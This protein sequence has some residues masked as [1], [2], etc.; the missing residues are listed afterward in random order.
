MAIKRMN[1]YK[2]EFLHAEDFQCEQIF[3]SSLRKIHNLSLHTLGI[4]YGL[5]VT[6]GAGKVTVKQGMAIDSQGREL[7]LDADRDVAVNSPTNITIAYWE[8]DDAPITEAGFT[9]VKQSTVTC[10][11][12]AGT[13]PDGIVL[14]TVTNAA[15]NPVTLNTAYKR[16]YASPVANGDVTIGGNL[17]VK[18]KLTV[19]G[20]TRMVNTDRLEGNVILGDADTDTVTVEGSLLTG[21]TSG[22][23]KIGSPVDITGALSVTESISLPSSKEI[24]FADNGQIRCFDNN[25]RILFRRTE[26][27]LELREYGD[28]V[29][30][31]GATA[32]VETAKVVMQ[33]NGNVGI[34]TTNPSAHLEI[35][36]GWGDWF[37]LKQQRTVEG[38]GGFRIHNP[39]GEANVPQG[40]PS[41]NRLE[42]AYQTSAGI[43]NWGQFVIQGTTGNVGIG[44][45]TPDR[46]LTIAN[47]TASSYMNVKDNAHEILLG[48]D[49]N[50]GILSV[51][52]NHDLVLRAG[53]NSEKMRVTAGGKVGIGTSNPGAKLE[54]AGTIKSTMWNI[55]QVFNN[56]AGSMPKSKQF[57]MGG[58]VLLV[59]ASGSGW[60]NNSGQIGMEIKINNVLKGIAKCFTNEA[61][62]HKT[63]SANFL[64]VNGIAAG[65]HTLS[66]TALTG[67]NT[68]VNDFFSVTILELPFD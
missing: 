38:G 14:A 18:G 2:G 43:V 62:S 22:K 51:M 50:V 21:H 63:F 53:A 1:Y 16:S 25:H 54:V 27:K 64:V 42:I 66:L 58:G 3:Q 34:G 33:S 52:S 24:V 29:F 23:L 10:K 44:T 65:S 40:D 32:G 19:Q 57:T 49:G 9:G 20:D 13:D 7:I 41:R 26:N 30:S 6:A 47:T 15:T 60:S 46:S 17:E 56:E 39:W 5:E 45:A 8:V 35:N 68:D 61:S 37:F 4:V 48:V 28:L 55:T 11:I 36:N 31:P 59:F 12:I 67:T